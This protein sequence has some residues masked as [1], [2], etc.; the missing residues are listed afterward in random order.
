MIGVDQMTNSI[1]VGALE[2]PWSGHLNR[3]PQEHYHHW[4]NGGQF[5]LPVELF[6]D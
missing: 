3:L 1:I 5:E 4:R 2:V 6:N